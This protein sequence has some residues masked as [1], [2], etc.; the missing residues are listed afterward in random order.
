MTR[1][2]FTDAYA[3]RPPAGTRA[4]LVEE[5]NRVRM[6]FWADPGDKALREE[7]ER[8]QTEL[9]RLDRVGGVGHDDGAHRHRQGAARP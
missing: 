2:F 6:L 4:A 7:L 1:L 5:R 9:R 8:L 3:N